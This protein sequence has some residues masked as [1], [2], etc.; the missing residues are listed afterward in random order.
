MLSKPIIFIVAFIGMLAVIITGLQNVSISMSTSLDATEPNPEF[1]IMERF[2]ASD[3]IVYNTVHSNTTYFG[4]GNSEFIDLTGFPGEH[5]EIWWSYDASPTGMPYQAFE[6]RH[7]KPGFLGWWVDRE[8][9]LWKLKNGQYLDVDRGHYM[10]TKDDLILGF[11]GE[12]NA[13]AYYISCPHYSSSILVSRYHNNET[14]WQSW[15]LG[16]MNYT[17]TYSFNPNSTGFNAFS[18]LS[19]VVGFTNP[20]LGIAGAFGTVFDTAIALALWGAR[21]FIIYKIVMGIVPWA[22]GGSGD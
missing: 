3:L 15:D 1:E 21:L 16:R 20:S 18:I 11:D 22:S 2:K 14:L 13:S 19:M 17:L 12:A 10:L 9:L 7:L 8:S 5:L 4:E 6:V